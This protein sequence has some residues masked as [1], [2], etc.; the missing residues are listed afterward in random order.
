M[1][2]SKINTIE[3]HLDKVGS[4]FLLA[5]LTMIRTNQLIKGARPSKGLPRELD[6]HYQ[7]EIT[8]ETLPKVALEEIRLGKLKWERKESAFI[9]KPSNNIIFEGK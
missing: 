8:H 7:G 1:L 4:R 5:T 2:T 3:E 9:E 6:Q